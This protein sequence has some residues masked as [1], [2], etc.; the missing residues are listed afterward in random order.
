MV[1]RLPDYFNCE[2]AGHRAADYP[3]TELCSVCFSAENL[4]C[5]CAFTVHS[6]NIQ[7]RVEG[8]GSA[9]FVAAVQDGPPRVKPPPQAN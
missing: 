7:A 3:E 8:Q 5:R 1:V 9:S 2:K 6:A 4:T